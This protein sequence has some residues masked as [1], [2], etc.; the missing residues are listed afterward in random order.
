MIIL[1]KTENIDYLFIINPNTTI[2][3]TITNPAIHKNAEGTASHFNASLAASVLPS[4]EAFKA[5]NIQNDEYP[6]PPNP[7][8]MAVIVFIF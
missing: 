4:I 1:I 2:H 8:A 5:A 7:R 3:N 6:S